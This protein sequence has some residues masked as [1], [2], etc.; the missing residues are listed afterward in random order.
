[1]LIQF[2][3]LGMKGFDFGNSGLEEKLKTVKSKAGSLSFLRLIVFVVM[4]GL[5]V[6]SVSENLIF[7][8]AFGASVVAFVSLIRNYNYQKDQEAIYLALV[9]MNRYRQLRVE[10]KLKELDAGIEFQEKAHPFS[11][12]LDLFG[13]HSLFQLLDHTVSKKGKEALA[14]KI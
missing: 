6:L 11:N 1:S 9:K 3:S 8:L 2:L 4:I 7:L 12:D 14:A 5:F 13:D 10:R